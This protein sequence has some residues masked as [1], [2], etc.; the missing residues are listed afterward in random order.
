MSVLEDGFAAEL[1]ADA[2]AEGAYDDTKLH[3]GSDLWPGACAMKTWLRLTVA[4]RAPE[5]LETLLRFYRGR[6]A[7]SLATRAAVR[8]G[9]LA[10]TQVALT[11]ERPSALD[12]TGH[13]DAILT[14]GEVV[15]AK[16]PK[17]EHFARSAGNIFRLIKDSWRWQLS[18]Y[19]HEARAR[20]LAT[21]GVFY[22]IDFEGSHGVLEIPLEAV[23]EVSLNEII[24]AET[25][26]HALLEGVKP[27]PI[28]RE[29]EIRVWKG[30][31]KT[32][33]RLEA[34]GRR[35]WQCGYCPYRGVSCHPGEETTPVLLGDG[36]RETALE[37]AE[38][39][40]KNGDKTTPQLIRPGDDLELELR[41]LPKVAFDTPEDTEFTIQ[42]AEEPG[43]NFGY[44]QDPPTHN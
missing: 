9:T 18:A 22:L 23:G 16:A 32:G 38:T 6:I 14:T 33:R 1:R 3:Y 8:A 13:A 7:E 42:H 43:F 39:R 37:I 11:P 24:S 31:G 35:N 2:E 36:R 28:A 29:L 10:A 12:W 21:R 34:N 5:S 4:P 20:G 41:G 27:E 44:P 15:E 30:R 17:A 25:T 19:V 26:K 40:W